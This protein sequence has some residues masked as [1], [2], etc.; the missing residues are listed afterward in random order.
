[1]L[2]ACLSRASVALA[3]VIAVA[4]PAAAAPKKAAAPKPDAMP[5]GQKWVTTWAASVQGPYPVGNPSAQPDQKFAFPVP[6]AGARDQTFR[7][8]VQ[9]EIWSQKVRLRFSN[10]F[11]TKPIAFDGIY[12][13]CS[14]RVRRSSPAPTS[15]SISAAR[16]A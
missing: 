15:R 3:F 12:V 4:L 6:A 9:P 8:I 13:G 1:M 16:P 11:G 14:S 10:A 2:P 5:A 7:L